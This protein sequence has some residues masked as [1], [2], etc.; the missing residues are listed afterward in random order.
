MVLANQMTTTARAMRQ[1]KRTC[2]PGGIN[3]LAR[4]SRRDW[5]P[6]FSLNQTSNPK[7]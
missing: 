1:T 7:Q 2:F 4:F 5:C 6:S 3:R